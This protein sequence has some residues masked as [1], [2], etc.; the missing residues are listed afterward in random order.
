MNT[1]ESMFS[2][3]GR[4]ALVTG[5]T[6]HLGR[7]VALAFAAAG[8]HVLVN[9]RSADAVAELVGMIRASGGQATPLAFDIRDAGAVRDVLGRFEGPLHALV[10]NAYVGGAGRLEGADPQAYRDSY[11]VAVV[12]ADGLLQAALPALR[13]GAKVRGGA[14][15]INIASMYG[16]IS[17]D[18]RLYDAS[19]GV[20]PPFYGAAKAALIQWTRYAACEFGPQGIRFNSVS[21]GPFPSDAIQQDN[22]DFVRRLEAKV[23]MGRIGNADEVA[24]P[25]LFLASPAS[26]YVNGTNLVVD[27]GWTAW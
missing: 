10:N 16:M 14:S 7:Q 17:P 8:G 2:M 13:L 6:G 3:H 15:V 5:A 26:S 27:G 24:G 12:A 9:A 23:P 19:S 1:F 18:A 25:V 21:P 20:N 22:P 4:S 11:E